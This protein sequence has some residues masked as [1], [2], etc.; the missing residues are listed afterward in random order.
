MNQ[1]EFEERWTN[2]EPRVRAF[3]AAACCNSGLVDDFA[4]EVAATAWRKRSQ[5]DDERSF[6][7]W[8]LGIARFVL[9][10]HRRDKARSKWILAPDIIDRLEELVYSED[11]PDSSLADALSACVASL[12]QSDQTLLSTR[13]ENDQPLA[14]VAVQMGR[15]HGAI[16]TALVRL[17]EKLKR[18]I[19]VRLNGTP[20]R[21]TDFR[22]EI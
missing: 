16:R 1:R 18:C 17:R 14:D 7:A 5:F 19:E 6:G 3:L 2:E 9:M 4:Q 13:Y 11:D 10:R 21:N 20:H 8:L 12:S 15:S 22:E